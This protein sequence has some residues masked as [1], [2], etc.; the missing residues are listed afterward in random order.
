[1]KIVNAE[2]KSKPR[3]VRKRKHSL[4]GPTGSPYLDETLLF[5]TRN[6]KWFPS[7]KPRNS[8]KKVTFSKYTLLKMTNKNE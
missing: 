3:R 6:I 4:V 5:Y 7:K 2:N 1:M 8:T